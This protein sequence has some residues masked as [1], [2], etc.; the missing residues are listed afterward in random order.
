M[1]RYVSLACVGI[2]M[3]S[4]LAGC[5]TTEPASSGSGNAGSQVASVSENVNLTSEEPTTVSKTEEATTEGAS[6]DTSE[7]VTASEEQTEEDTEETSETT[8]QDTE[9]KTEQE[10]TTEATTSTTETVTEATTQASTE[11]VAQ[12]SGEYGSYN[13][14][15]YS[16]WFV[17]N[18]THTT[19][20]CQRDFDISQ[21]HAYYVNQN[22]GDNVIYLTFDC[23]YENGYTGQILDT[24]RD[25]DIKAVFFVTQH[26][27]ETQPDLVRRMR[28][29]GHL[30]GN[31][32]NHHPSLPTLSIEEQREELQSCANKMKEL[33]GYDMDPYIR[34]PMGEYSERTLKLM[35]DMGYCTVFWSM[36][37]LDYDVNNQPGA[38]YVVQHFE[39]YVHP[40]AVPLMH[41]VSQSN[42]EALPRLIETLRNSG[43]RFARLDEFAHF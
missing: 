13:N 41:V 33:T 26:Y 34:P 16:W 37:Y 8:E 21:Y 9:T 31:H 7:D 20:G 17:R 40:G 4:M 29:E 2:C 24:L 6:E 18:D 1:R 43:Y 30:V 11:A 35:E 12:A 39:Q 28:E 25:N 10:K 3:M 19:P 27:V 32:T 42:A 15:K 36:A 23:G 22:A 38:D 5:G 14:T